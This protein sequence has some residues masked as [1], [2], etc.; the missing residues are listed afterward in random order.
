MGFSERDTEKL[1]WGRYAY[2]V[3]LD[4]DPYCNTDRQAFRRVEDWL[5][6]RFKKA[7]HQSWK[8]EDHF[9]IHRLWRATAAYFDNRTDAEAFLKRFRRFATE[10]QR[11]G[12]PEQEAQLLLEERIVI[13]D[14]LYYHKFRYKVNLTL[15][16]TKDADFVDEWL[17]EWAKNADLKNGEDFVLTPSSGTLYLNDRDKILLIR[18][19]IGGH[20]K[21][22]EKV[23]LKTE[24]KEQA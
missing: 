18:L 20:F 8:K 17:D 14:A 23:V 2:K 12:S 13:K 1:Y 19:G 7:R 16:T 11:P 10:Y 4:V 5:L 21:N 24:I 6:S 3:T 15:K 9:R 22:V